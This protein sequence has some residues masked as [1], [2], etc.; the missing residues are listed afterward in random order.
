MSGASNI[1]WPEDLQIREFPEPY[2]GWLFFEVPGPPRPAARA[3]TVVNNGKRCTYTPSRTDAYEDHVASCAIVAMYHCKWVKERAI[4]F[5]LILDVHRRSRD[6]GDW[7]NYAK[8]VADGLTR[9]HA[10]KDD[11][12][13][14]EAVVRIHD[15]ETV[16]R[17]LVRVEVLGEEGS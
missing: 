2:G 9:A 3:R 10:W 15:N 12:W 11:R 8:A 4:P 6:Q 14:K 7:D 1:E 16:P 17:V 13:V 5:R